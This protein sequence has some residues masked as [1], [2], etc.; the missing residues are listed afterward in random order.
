MPRRLLT[1]EFMGVRLEQFNPGR[2]FTAL[3]MIEAN[4]L[5]YAVKKSGAVVTNNRTLFGRRISARSKMELAEVFY[6][7]GLISAEQRDVVN[8]SSSEELLRE[9]RAEA[10]EEVMHYAKQAGLELSVKQRA[11]IQKALDAASR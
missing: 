11:T 10:A 5:V 7:L 6:R 8:S 4:R 9:E 2:S 3:K 1:N